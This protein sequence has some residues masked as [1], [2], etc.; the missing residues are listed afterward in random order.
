[1]PIEVTVEI[2]IAGVKGRHYMRLEAECIP[3]NGDEIRLPHRIVD[4]S[5]PE[6]YTGESGVVFRVVRHIYDVIDGSVKLMCCAE[7]PHAK[8]VVRELASGDR[9]FELAQSEEEMCEY[10]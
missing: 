7:S 8:S 2:W 10:E 9:C 3:H 4:K 6:M 5:A 1:M